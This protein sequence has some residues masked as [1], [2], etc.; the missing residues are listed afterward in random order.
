MDQIFIA[1]RCGTVHVPRYL[2]LLVVN[3]SHPKP[4]VDGIKKVVRIGCIMLVESD[5]MLLV[6]HCLILVESDLILVKRSLILV[7]SGFML[8]ESGLMLVE[9]WS[10]VILCRS[11]IVSQ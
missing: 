2:I 9:H 8:I 11:N 3:R 6:E 5:V 4:R 10:K 1:Y 7:Q